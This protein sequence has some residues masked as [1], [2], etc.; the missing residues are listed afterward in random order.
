MSDHHHHNHAHDDNIRWAFLLNFGFTLLEIFGGIWTNSIAILSDALHDLGDS[1]S[2]GLAWFLSRFAKKKHDATYS[3]GYLRFS[4][5]GAMINILVLLIG[6]VFVLSKSIPRLLN[7]EVAH[8]P[9][10]LIFALIGI[11][12]NGIAALRMRKDHSLNSRIVF[13]HL[14]EDVL[15]WMGVLI[16]SIVLLFTDW[17]FLDALFSLFI[18]LYILINVI[19]NLKKTLALFMQA[20]PEGI[21]VDEIERRILTIE[22]VVSCHHTHCWSLDG[23]NHV[24][25][26]HVVVG[27]NAKK[28][29]VIQ[30]KCAIRRMA[31]SLHFEHIT[32]ETEYEDE[33]C[34]MHEKQDHDCLSDDD[35]KGV[36]GKN[37]D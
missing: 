6:S 9:G 2:I 29:D 10:M 34:S 23:E 25:S 5:L 21:P 11:S 1:V 31:Q 36:L 20:I 18:T 4:L 26:T 19:R 24:L 32:V 22:S 3:Y 35:L 33:T 8:A 17:Y 16:V 28:E 12:V 14:M 13:L 27:K 37:H 30:I 15:G 7:P